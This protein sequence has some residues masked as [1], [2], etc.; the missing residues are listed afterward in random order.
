M[1]PVIIGT[2]ETTKLGPGMVPVKVLSVTWTAGTYG[3]FTETSTW[4]ELSDGTLMGILRTK[5]AALS[6]LPTS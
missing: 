4:S 5:A 3:P 1:N 6:T 2:K